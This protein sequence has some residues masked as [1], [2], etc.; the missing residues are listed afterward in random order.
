MHT[1]GNT[2]VNLTP[3]GPY[4]FISGARGQCEKG[5]KLQVIVLSTKHVRP[6]TAS[7]APS[8]VGGPPTGHGD[9]LEGLWLAALGALMG[10]GYILM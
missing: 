8:P 2:T 6:A 4:Y 3:S 9:R 1:D 10:L 7:P 5:Q